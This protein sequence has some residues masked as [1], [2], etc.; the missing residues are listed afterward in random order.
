MATAAG[1]TLLI[2]LAHRLVGSW[3]WLPVEAFGVVVGV[4]LVADWLLSGRSNKEA[5][6]GLA[7]FIASILMIIVHSQ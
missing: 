3:V 2:D 1:G 5:L 4:G 6:A 7:V